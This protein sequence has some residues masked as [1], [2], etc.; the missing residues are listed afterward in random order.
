MSDSLQKAFRSILLNESG[1]VDVV[2]DK[3]RPDALSEGDSLPAVLLEVPSVKPL[4]TLELMDPQEDRATVVIVCC[5]HKREDA[6]ALGQ[7]VRTAVNGFSGDVGDLTFQSV[8]VTEIEDAHEPAE[9][10][11]DQHDWYLRLLKCD[12]WYG[13]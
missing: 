9:D 13:R 12:V 8:A 10:G 1:I 7:L 3:V 4:E 5:A 6:K 11:T 2:G